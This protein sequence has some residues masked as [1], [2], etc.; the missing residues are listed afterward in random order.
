MS[1][2][3]TPRR[4]RSLQGRGC[5]SSRSSSSRG[6]GR[7]SS[8][9]GRGRSSSSRGSTGGTQEV[10]I[11]AP[12]AG[13]EFARKRRKLMDDF[14]AM[15]RENPLNLADT[16]LLLLEPVL[17]NNRTAVDVQ[18]QNSHCAAE[19]RQEVLLEPPDFDT[20]LKPNPGDDDEDRDLLLAIQLH[21]NLM[22]VVD[23]RRYQNLLYLL[24][25]LKNDITDL[26]D[27]L[28][29]P[30]PVTSSRSTETS[31]YDCTAMYNSLAQ[32]LSSK[33]NLSSFGVLVFLSKAQKHSEEMRIASALSVA[34]GGVT[35]TTALQ[36]K[37]GQS[38]QA[39]QAPRKPGFK[40]WYYFCAFCDNKSTSQLHF[41]G[42]FPLECRSDGC[43]SW[44]QTKRLCC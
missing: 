36:N 3:N 33:T 19:K 17:P 14:R 21:L 9:R 1:T 28:K 26:Q 39:L 6:R 10:S 16:Q 7:S 29:S 11:Q 2:G 20:L 37:S 43:F 35:F 40:V 15:V 31:A 22:G 30:V 23:R 41:F 18:L 5:S 25:S 24:T 38:C 12:D 27:T 32:Y 34:P 44:K 4:S 8:S 42:F 13:G